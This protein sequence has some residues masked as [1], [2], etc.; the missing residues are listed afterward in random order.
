M[1]NVL[2]TGAA[3]GLGLEFAR[4]YKN[5]GW[6]V[7]ATARQPGGEL[8]ALGVD[9]RTLD[10]ADFQAVE[11][12]GRAF[13]RPLD[14]LIA[15]AGIATPF[16]A[17]NARDAEGW[18]TVFRVNSVAPVL[19]AQALLPRLEEARGKAIAISSQMGSIA[20]ASSGWIPY[21]SSKS[22]LNMAWHALANEVRDKGVAMATLHPGWVQTDMGGPDA[23]IDPATSITG[24]RRVIDDLDL[25]GTGGFIAYDGKTLPW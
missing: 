24:M 21:R 10:V 8:S 23:T 25:G 17:R 9:V 13:D 22:A 12:F 19:L 15:N 1:P 3:R 18:M 6:D 14:L 4:Q 5:D 7:I 20:D 16:E 11:E 2:I